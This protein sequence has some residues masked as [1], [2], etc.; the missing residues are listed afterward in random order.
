MQAGAKHGDLPR[1]LAAARALA[2]GRRL[3]IRY[4]DA[5]GAASTRLV[6][7]LGLAWRGDHWLLAAHCHLRRALRHFCLHRILAARRVRGRVAD[8]HA[9]PGFDARFFSAES[10]L[11][12]GP[13][14]PAL[15]TVRLAVP[16]AEVAASLF[17]AALLEWPAPGTALCHLR[18]TDPAA[19][20]RLVESLGA[21]A[22]LTPLMPAQAD[23][24]SPEPAP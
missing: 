8:R 12:S 2:A 16:L 3:R 1:L 20:A 4:R 15:A 7:P 6:S 21:A 17:P 14:P 23:G 18:V 22:S 9:P 24:D 5:A 11:R 10:Y 13:V 19:L